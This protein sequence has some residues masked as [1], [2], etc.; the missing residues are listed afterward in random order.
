MDQPRFVGAIRGG[1]TS[2]PAEVEPRA[3]SH[4]QFAHKA[5]RDCPRHSPAL[6]ARNLIVAMMVAWWVECA[7]ALEKANIERVFA[8]DPIHLVHREDQCRRL[9]SETVN[10]RRGP[11]PLEDHKIMPEV[12]WKKLI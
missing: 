7:L 2:S 5:I 10:Q 9:V 6:A 8:Q 4:S 3:I 12:R 1:A 11:C